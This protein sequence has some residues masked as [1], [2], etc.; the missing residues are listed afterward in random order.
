MC[1][2]RCHGIGKLFPPPSAWQHPHRPYRACTEI[3]SH[4]S[5]GA[6]EGIISGNSES[7]QK[8]GKRKRAKRQTILS[9]W[10]RRLHGIRQ[11]VP[12]ASAIPSEPTPANVEAPQPGRF[13]ANWLLSGRCRSRCRQRNSSGQFIVASEMRGNAK[14]M[15]LFSLAVRI[16]PLLHRCSSGHPPFR[17]RCPIS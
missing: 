15:I 5:P 11:L 9:P 12:L 17:V 4:A 6:D 16:P 3:L 14:Q 8:E 10:S 13:T 2:R 1:T 7:R